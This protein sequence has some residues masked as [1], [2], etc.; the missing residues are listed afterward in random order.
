MFILFM[1]IGLKPRL[2]KLPLGFDFSNWA[3]THIILCVCKCFP[4]NGSK[5]I[6]LIHWNLV[7]AWKFKSRNSRFWT[8]AR[9][10]GV[11]IEREIRAPNT[12]HCFEVRSS[13]WIDA[14]TGPCVLRSSGC[15]A[16]IA[17]DFWASSTFGMYY[18][19]L[20]R[21]NSRSS[22]VFCLSLRS[23]GLTHARAGPLFSE[24]FAKCLKV[25]LCILI[26]F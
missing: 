3:L 25:H 14:R 19:P 21:S 13:G 12:L 24:N 23:S 1:K 10:G 5:G 6:D 26:S 15:R 7:W 18:S 9:A 4:R 2:I 11:A 8:L 16:P 20:E 22:V 17:R